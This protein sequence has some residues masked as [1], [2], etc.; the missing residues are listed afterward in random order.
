MRMPWH[1][2]RGVQLDLAGLDPGPDSVPSIEDAPSTPCDASLVPLAI[3]ALIPVVEDPPGRAA[4]VAIH[5]L[6][7]DRNN[8]RT[9]FPDAE[10][11]ELA[12]DIRQHGALQPIV[13]HPADGD[14]RHLVHFGS[15]RLRAA[16]RAGPDP[17]SGRRS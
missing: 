1:K 13:V 2:S 12:E 11:E 6:D 8:P 4:L 7:E 10:L 17:R 9:E 14:G 15:K 5:L 3:E 16:G